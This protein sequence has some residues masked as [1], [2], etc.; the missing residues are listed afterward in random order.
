MKLSSKNFDD[1]EMLPNKYTCDDESVSPE[2][3]W[4]NFPQDTKSFAFVI[5]DPDAP[6]GTFTHWMAVN[7]PVN[8]TSIPERNVNI[9]E[10]LMI[11]NTAGKFEYVAPCPPSGIHHYVFKVFALKIAKLENVTLENFYQ[12]INPYIIANAKLVGKFSR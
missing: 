9:P 1:N 8:I 4:N 2:L 11:K 12:K 7:I 3:S 5:E 6:N 10:G